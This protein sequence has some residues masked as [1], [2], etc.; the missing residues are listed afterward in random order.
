MKLIIDIP[1]YVYEH[2][3]E[4]TEDSRDEGIVMDAIRKGAPLIKHQIAEASTIIK[5]S[6]G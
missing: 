1:Y 3:K 4:Y 5:T 2:A 6:E